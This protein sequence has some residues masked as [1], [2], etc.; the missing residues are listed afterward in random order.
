MT[1]STTHSPSLTSTRRTQSDDGGVGFLERSHVL[2]A[3]EAL[4][5]LGHLHHVV[6]GVTH[7]VFLLGD[8]AGIQVGKELVRLLLVHLFEVGHSLLVHLHFSLRTHEV[9]YLPTLPCCHSSK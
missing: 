1:A 8:V 2:P 4:P 7:V 9:L 6:L 5:G 3:A